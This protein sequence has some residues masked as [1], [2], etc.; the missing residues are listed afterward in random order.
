MGGVSAIQETPF[1]FS[2]GSNTNDLGFHKGRY[3]KSVAEVQ[4]VTF[5]VYSV[6]TTSVYRSCVGWRLSKKDTAKR[7]LRVKPVRIG[8]TCP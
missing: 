7:K 4:T 8:D 5:C 1:V 3:C 6:C 2:M